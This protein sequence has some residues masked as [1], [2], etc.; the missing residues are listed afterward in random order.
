MKVNEIGH[1]N[2]VSNASKMSRTKKVKKEQSADKLE[3]SREAKA[4]AESSSK[5]SSDRIA[6]IK[7][8]I[9]ENFYD[10]DDVLDVVAKRM[11]K[12][13]NYKEFFIGNKP[14]KNL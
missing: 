11:L 5:L 8:R 2:F 6:E 14:S 12:S 9:E 3:I 13:P 1:L 7:K 10:K 4:L